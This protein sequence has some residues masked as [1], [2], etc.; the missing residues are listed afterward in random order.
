MDLS[1]KELKIIDL[2]RHN[3]NIH[4]LIRYLK[5]F[6][7][8]PGDWVIKTWK[9]YDTQRWIPTKISMTNP[10][11][12]KFKIVHVDEEGVPWFKSL[13]VNGELADDLHWIEGW[14]CDVERLE[15]D[16]DYIDYVLLE[17]EEEYDPLATY[18]MMKRNK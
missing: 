7:F 9:E 2:R 4:G 17:C 12:K 18:K 10:A 13:K 6:K 11:P 1:D 14:S 16:P 3:S 15:P 5:E 8:K